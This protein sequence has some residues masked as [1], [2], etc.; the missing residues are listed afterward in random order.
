MPEKLKCLELSFLS[1][2]H[3]LLIDIDIIEVV[4]H[5]VDQVGEVVLV[6]ALS[7]VL[8]HQPVREGQ[9]ARNLV[10]I[11]CARFNFDNS[12]SEHLFSSLPLLTAASLKRFVALHCVGYNFTRFANLKSNL[13]MMVFMLYAPHFLTDGTHTGTILNG[14]VSKKCKKKERKPEHNGDTGDDG[15]EHEPEPENNINL[16]IFLL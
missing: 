12:P 4:C 13:S 10:T 9:P 14:I 5:H 3:L 15:Q 16:A 2:S 11:I 6:H 1:V 8:H 7:Q